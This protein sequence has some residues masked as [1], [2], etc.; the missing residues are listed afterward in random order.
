MPPNK[1]KRNVK[2]VRNRFTI[3]LVEM[4]VKKKASLAAKKS[5]RSIKAIPTQVLNKRFLT[6][7]FDRQS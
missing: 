6:P 2:G 5:A 1:P 4:A 7:F 3:F